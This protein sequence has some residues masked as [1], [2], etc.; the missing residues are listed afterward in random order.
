MSHW[1]TLYDVPVP[2][3]LW[4]SRRRKKKISRLWRITWLKSIFLI[5]KPIYFPCC[6]SQ[7]TESFLYRGFGQGGS[8]GVLFVLIWLLF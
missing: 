4:K 5:F 3:Y 1:A 7:K 2:S 8:N 6:S